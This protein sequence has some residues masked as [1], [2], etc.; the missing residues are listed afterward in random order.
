MKEMSRKGG[1][2]WGTTNDMLSIVLGGKK[3]EYEGWRILIEGWLER[4]SEI[5]WIV[6][7]EE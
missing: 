1:E 2:N 4:I 5:F 3:E 7:K 6:N